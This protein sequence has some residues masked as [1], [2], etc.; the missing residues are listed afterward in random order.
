MAAFVLAVSSAGLADW[1]PGD[2]FKMHH[3]QEPDLQG[4]DI[5]WSG[6]P[7]MDDF[8]CIES[9]LIT[10]IHFWI[11]FQ[12]DQIFDLNPADFIIEIWDDADC[13]PGNRLWS[14]DQSGVFTAR[15]YEDG[16]QGWYCM[17]EQVYPDHSQIWQINITE[18]GNPF[19][20]ESENIYWLMIHYV[21]PAPVGW[22]TTLPDLRFNC[23]ALM[24]SL[25]GGLTPILVEGMER[26]LAFVITGE[27]GPQEEFDWG[28]APDRPYP[29][30]SV[31]NGANHLIVR[32]IQM[33]PSIDGEP[34]GQPDPQALG[35][36]NDILYPPVNDDED[37]V[38]FLTNPLVPGFPAQVDVTVSVDG[39]LD[40]WVDFDQ[41]GSWAEAADQIFTAQPVFAGLNT[42]TF[43]VPS[44]IG[45]GFVTPFTFARFRFSTIGGLP[46]DGRAEDGE[47][48][49]YQ[50]EIAEEPEEVADLGDAPDS[51]N[52]HRT[53]MRAYPGVPA[54]FPTVFNDPIGSLPVGPIHYNP[55]SA[56]Y[57]GET[58]TGEIEADIGPDMDI[59]NNIDPPNDSP[60]Q[61]GGDDCLPNMPLNL[62]G[63]K[64]TTFDYLVNIQAVPVSPTPYYV[65]VW[66]DFN[67]DGDWD[68]SGLTDPALMCPLGPVDEWAVKNQVIIGLAPGIHAITS[69]AFLSKH[70][71]DLPEEIWM[72]ITLSEKPWTG[73]DYGPDLIGLGG[74]GPINGYQIG[75]TEDYIFVPD[76]NCEECADLNCDNFVNLFDFAI[77]AS[78]WLTNCY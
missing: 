65:N 4:W 39:F 16:M 15:F 6:G 7:L 55:S 40:A 38:I 63:C 51:S 3:P 32:G 70:F 31:N 14:W 48:E 20:Q 47:V 28:D 37:G 58:V 78:Q 12:G 8:L 52:N 22:K 67:R 11:S 71:P 46:Y 56:A 41:N 53:A 21:G 76:T 61:D 68:D 50:I 60:D 23:P 54:N 43:H 75:E 29:T 17:G 24:Q 30:L 35:D 69:H 10:D 1:N 2:P 18:I 72:R 73:S 44:G 59:V 45:G 27:P 34:D 57:L 64:Y 9:G 66:F 49:D 19:L 26:D 13:K 42:L 74:S 33:G 5:C 62:P 36:D 25:T 77:F